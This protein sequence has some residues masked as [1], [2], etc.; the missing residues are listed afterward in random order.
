MLHMYSVLSFVS[1]LD[2]EEKAALS[3]ALRPFFSL[4][5]CPSVPG[6]STFTHDDPLPYQ[7][8]S[9]FA[10]ICRLFSLQKDT[11]G[12]FNVRHIITTQQNTE[13][14]ECVH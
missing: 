3:V 11:L 12:R 13:N 8:M 6:H 7:E 2:D 10:T 1:H 4:S 14:K 9:N 5:V